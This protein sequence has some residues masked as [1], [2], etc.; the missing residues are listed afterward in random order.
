MTNKAIVSTVVFISLIMAVPLSAKGP[1]AWKKGP[2]LGILTDIEIVHITYIREEEKL[3]RDVYLTLYDLRQVPIFLNISESE[4]RH[5]DSM[6][7]LIDKYG[8]ADPVSDDTIG[9]FTNQVFTDLYIELVGRGNMS[10]CD[11]LQVGIDIELLDI[12]D[13]EVA[14]NDIEAQDVNRV[15]NN[16]LSGSYNHL[17]AF[18][19]Q[20][21]TAECQ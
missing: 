4:Q 3:A 9:K 21:V 12:E 1:S 16:L 15:L 2:S 13:I 20:Y 19:N 17:N 14:L 10:Y 8:I 18:T 6:K 5:M 11:A 7:R